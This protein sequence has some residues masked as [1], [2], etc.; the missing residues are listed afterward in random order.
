MYTGLD[1]SKKLIDSLLDLYDSVAHYFD[2]NLPLEMT[3]DN[4]QEFIL[5]QNC[6]ICSQLFTEDAIKTRDHS[7]ISGEWK[8]CCFSFL[9]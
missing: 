1:C 2:M 9:L 5:A 8:C 4:E 7:H 3:D 6:H